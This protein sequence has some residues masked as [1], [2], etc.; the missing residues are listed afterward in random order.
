MRKIISLWQSIPL[1][2]KS[3]V[4]FVILECLF[5]SRFTVLIGSGTSMSPTIEAN[6]LLLCKNDDNYQVGDIVYYKVDGKP[7]THRIIQIH[8]YVFKNDV[9]YTYTLRGDNNDSE[10]LFDVYKENIICKVIGK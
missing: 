1:F 10:D 7:I 9:L 3:L 2:Y 6:Q 5:F 8:R 4:I